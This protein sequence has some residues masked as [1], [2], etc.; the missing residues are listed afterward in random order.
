MRLRSTALLL[1]L[2]KNFF[3]DIIYPIFSHVNC[4]REK[5]GK[6]NKKIRL[7]TKNCT[8]LLIRS[9]LRTRF[10]TLIGVTSLFHLTPRSLRLVLRLASSPPFKDKHSVG[11]LLYEDLRRIFLIP[12]VLRL[13]ECRPLFILDINSV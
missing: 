2:A 10:E 8:F 1:H 12:Q 7:G 9:A 4:F 3:T 6:E 11:M 13:R 5:T